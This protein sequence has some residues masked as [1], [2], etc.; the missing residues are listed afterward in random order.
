VK[1]KIFS[2]LGFTLVE[3]LV[4]ISIM[5][6]L[7]TAAIYSYGSSQRREMFF[8]DVETVLL[9]LREARSNAILSAVPAGESESPSAF[10][11]HIE[12]TASG[13]NWNIETILFADI[14]NNNEFDSATDIIMK[15]DNT[16]QSMDFRFEN[17][18]PATTPPNNEL[19]VIFSVPNSEIILCSNNDSTT[20]LLE[21]DLIF[22][23]VGFQR[24][25][26][27]NRISRFFEFSGD[28]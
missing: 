27:I 12:R 20:T 16:L 1:K 9:N 2:S 8:S 10:G 7:A 14:N 23:I 28:T 22:E 24:S 19:T 26:H 5:G 25:I 4:T 13:S 18:I 3:L 21:T 6:I 11:V 15:T 17:S